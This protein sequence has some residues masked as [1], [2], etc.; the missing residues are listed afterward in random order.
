MIRGCIERTFRGYSQK[1][2]ASDL[3]GVV[4]YAWPIRGPGKRGR[5]TEAG[6]PDRS[7]HRDRGGPGKRKQG[8][9]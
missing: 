5:G 9:T 2:S 4:P 7:E 1:Q 3:K 6:T 8:S